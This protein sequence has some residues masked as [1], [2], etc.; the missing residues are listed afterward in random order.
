MDLK[1]VG[2]CEA[3]GQSHSILDTNFPK[4]LGSL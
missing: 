2:L 3:S 4:F 1:E